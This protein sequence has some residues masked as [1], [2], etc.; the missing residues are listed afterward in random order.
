[1]PTDTV[2]RSLLLFVCLLCTPAVLLRAQVSAVDAAEHEVV[3]PDQNLRFV[4]YQKENTAGKTG[5][6]YRVN[7]KNRPVVSESPLDIVLDN[8]LSENAMNQGFDRSVPWCETLVL[9]A[10]RTQ[11]TDTTWKPV[12]GERALVRD[13][14]NESVFEFTKTGSKHYGMQ[15]QVR[16]YNEGIAFRYFFPEDPTNIYYRVVSENTA[17]SFPAGTRAYFTPWAQ[18]PCTLLPLENWPDE[19]ERPLTL[20]L[21]DGTWVCLAEAAMV[22]YV[23]T[24]FRLD[25]TR[26]NTVLTAMHEPIDQ[27]TPFGTP[28]RVIMVAEQAGQLVENNDLILNLNAPCAIKNTDWIKPGKIIREM[29]LTTAGGRACIDYAAAHG[30]RYILF[31][32][33]WYGPAFTFRSDATKVIADIDMPGLIRYGQEKGVG[34][35]LYVNQQALLTQR[36]SLFPILQRWG[37]KGIKFGFVQL[38]SH[39]WS[40]WLHETVRY[41]A[42]HELMVNIHDEYRPT[43]FS[44]TYPNLMTQEGIRG[45]EEFPDAAHSTIL[46]FTRFIAGAGDHTVCYYTNRLV[47]THGH[48]MA[49]AVLFYS[50][51]QTLFWYDKPSDYQGEPEVEFFEKIPAVWDD[52]R[53]LVGEPGK[54][55][56]MAR[57]SGDAWFVGAITNTEGREITVPLDFLPQGKT[58]IA[59]LY[60]DDPAVPTRTH[61]KL[62][63]RRLRYGE[64]L[65][66]N[67]LPS[68]GAALWLRPE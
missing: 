39:R 17:F 21:P 53:V 4:F 57:R 13:H 32:W 29:T 66:L 48:Q 49:L 34:I 56:V 24:K 68:G 35:W 38:G 47:T 18:G 37:V 26:P 44:R 36:D 31:D 28:W 8:H 55:V 22:D 11:S 20:T 45:N 54:Q 5:F 50:P 3:S 60:T 64:T 63:Q 58:F 15:F 9:S 62:E 52:T 43:G 2:F 19:S 10:I 42:E 27:I 46:P 14:Y 67:L 6:F 25:P 51:I 41:A 23:R 61:V 40:A 12:Y 33:K 30:L 59:T 16:A 7:Y 1:M 65:H